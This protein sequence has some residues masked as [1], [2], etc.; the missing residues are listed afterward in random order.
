MNP[1]DPVTEAL[2]IAPSPGEQLQAARLA[3]G[4]S[5]QEIA[6][7]LRIRAAL[8]DALESGDYAPF[9]AA[10]YARG[11]LRN[12]ARLLGLDDEALLAGFRAVALDAAGKPLYRAPEL[13][14]GRP[15]LVR[16]GGL[17]I[18]GV[19]AV[20]GALWAGAGRAPD[21]PAPQPAS[22]AAVPAQE[23]PSETPPALAPPAPEPVAE[24]AAALPNPA[25]DIPAPLGPTLAEAPAAP[26]APAA[27]APAADLSGV[28]LR[29][30]S[31]SVSWVEVTDHAGQR[32]IY[33]LV[34]PGPER[35]V[36]GQPPLRLL[37]GNA[38]GVE[39]V[40]EGAPLALPPG[41]HVVRMTLGA[42]EPSAAAGAQPPP[43]GAAS[44]AQSP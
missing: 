38:P 1:R 13:H 22:T 3:R 9:K 33:E 14:P 29:L 44:P 6:G 26:P 2:P 35:V 39:I 34:S 7:R 28:E 27:P 43:P 19:V 42:A 41:Q 32:L 5:T 37:L 18:V 25:Q 17:A 20:L 36:R 40:F 8:V 12:Y 15:W 10:A 31:R 21:A 16:L 11:Q 30:R 23:A 24:S 4:W